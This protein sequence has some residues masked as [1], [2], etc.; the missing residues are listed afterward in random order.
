MTVNNITH[1]IFRFSRTSIS[2]K[3][4]KLAIFFGSV[5]YTSIFI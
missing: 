2:Q 1:Y 3:A 5:D 4:S